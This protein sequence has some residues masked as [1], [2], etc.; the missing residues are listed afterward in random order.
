MRLVPRIKRTG[1]VAFENFPERIRG[2]ADRDYFALLVRSLATRTVDGVLFP[3]FPRDVIQ[4]NFV[5]SS[6]TQALEEAMTFWVFRKTT[7]TPLGHSV[8]RSS[9]VLDFG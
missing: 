7:A 8:R 1:V 4:S 3:G 5:G 2:L 6:G 9:N